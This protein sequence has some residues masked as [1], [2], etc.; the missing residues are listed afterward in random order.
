[1]IFTSDSFDVPIVSINIGDILKTTFIISI[2][3]LTFFLAIMK[4]I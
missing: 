2:T 3:R 4:G 1:M